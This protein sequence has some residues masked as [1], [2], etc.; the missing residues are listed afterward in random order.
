MSKLVL[1]NEKIV[2]WSQNNMFSYDAEQ[3][4]G[5]YK[6]EGTDIYES[7]GF[8]ASHIMCIIR[9]L[10]ERYDLDENDFVY[11]AKSNKLLVKKG[12]YD[13]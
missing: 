11:S 10:L 7:I 13:E 5:D 9:A 6:I 4:S 12:D 1:N 8:S 3:V 2:S